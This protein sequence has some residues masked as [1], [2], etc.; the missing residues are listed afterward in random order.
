VPAA[1]RVQ[2]RWTVSWEMHCGGGGGG[3]GGGGEVDGGG[4]GGTITVTVTSTEPALSPK[5]ASPSWMRNAN[6]PSRSTVNAPSLPM[7]KNDGAPPILASNMPYGICGSNLHPWKI[8][9]SSSKRV[10]LRADER[11]SYD[12]RHSRN[13]MRKRIAVAPRLRSETWSA[14]R[15][16]HRR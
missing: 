16:L 7:T 5:Q 10:T 9:P 6:A 2:T 12:G 14:T 15:A 13:Q 3:G 4:G 8:R 1:S 11:E